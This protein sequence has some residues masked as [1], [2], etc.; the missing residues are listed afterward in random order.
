MRPTPHALVPAALPSTIGDLKVLETLAVGDNALTGMC[1]CSVVPIVRPTPHT[2]VP[3]AVPDSIGELQALTVL[4]LQFN[5]LSG[6]CLRVVPVL[7]C[8]TTFCITDAEKAR[9][10]AALPNCGR[11]Y[12]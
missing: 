3:A 7:H 4:N 6:T 10:R 8:L 2:L 11:L 1:F 12:L 9:V 5:S